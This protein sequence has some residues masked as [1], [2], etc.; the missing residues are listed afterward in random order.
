MKKS[1]VLFL[2]A[3]FIFLSSCRDIRKE[4]YANGVLKQQ[5]QF[6][7][8]QPNGVATWFYENGK[9]MMEC[10]YVNGSIEGKMTRWNFTGSV[11]SQVMFKNNIRNGMS[12][13]NYE[14]GTPFLEDEYVNDTLNGMHVE[15][16]PN[17]QIKVKGKNK[18]NLWDGKWEYFDER[19]IKVGEATFNSGSGVLK[20]FYWNG[21]LK[22]TQCYAN[23]Q[24]DG[25]EIWYKENGEVE[26]NLTYKQDRIVGDDMK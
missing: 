15:Y 13:N 10:T 21:R 8:D 16:H 4:Y 22:R 18:N 26:K 25:K 6:T 7:H 14:N 19:G 12:I 2:S 17:G 5:I 3:L 1:C 20:G 23:N 24:R 11:E 9:K